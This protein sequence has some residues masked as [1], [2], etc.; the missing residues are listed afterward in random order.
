MKSEQLIGLAKRLELRVATERVLEDVLSNHQYGEHLDRYTFVHSVIENRPDLRKLLLSEDSSSRVTARQQLF[1]DL[2]TDISLLHGLAVVFRE[3]AASLMNTGQRNGRVPTISAALWGLVLSSKAFWKDFCKNR[4]DFDITK[5]N[6]FLEKAAESILRPHSAQAGLDYAAKRFE[7]AQVHVKCLNLWRQTPQDVIERLSECNLS[8][9]DSNPLLHLGYD[10]TKI[11]IMNRIASGMLDNFATILVEEASQLSEQGLDRLPAGIRKNYDAAIKHLL[12]FL[13]FAISES[14]IS[15]AALCYYSEWCGDLY[16][17]EE[18]TE[19]RK[20]VA[21]AEPVAN[22][23]ALISNKGQGYL[24]ENRILSRHYLLRGFYA[25]DEDTAI[26]QYRI[27][28][29]WDP[30]N[31]HAEKL[32]SER[33]AGRALKPALDEFQRGNH[34][35]A[36]RA[37]DKAESQNSESTLTDTAKEAIL[38]EII[39]TRFHVY[40]DRAFLHARSNSYDEAANDLKQAMEFA[41]HPDDQ[42]E[43]RKSW[44]MIMASQAVFWVN[45]YPYDSNARKEAKKQLEQALEIDPDNNYAKDN[46]GRI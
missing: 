25:E 19:A 6:G 23:L 45:T 24:P 2:P 40:I 35:A 7:S 14:R 46:L 27:A 43:A 16:I 1:K 12:P 30:T 42:V 29:E 26:Q 3:K 28:L 44:S 8:F 21:Q 5:Q 9:S 11:E 22:K 38:F 34:N 10:K 39:R 13:G 41:Y 36:L 4:E 31:D 37:L 33:L 20:L 32:L 17:K 18:L 15:H